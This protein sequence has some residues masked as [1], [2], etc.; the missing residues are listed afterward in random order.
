MPETRPHGIKS[1]FIE[2]IVVTLS[3]RIRSGVYPGG[4]W[5][6]TERELCSEFDV[7]RTTLRQALAELERSSLVMRSAGCRPMVIAGRA[8][9]HIGARNAETARRTIGLQVKHDA[10]F[11]G[12]YQITQGVRE[13]AGAHACRLIVG[14]GS[15]VTLAQAAS[16]EAQTLRDMTR[17]EDVEGIILWH[18]GVESLLPELLAVQQAGIPLVFVDRAPPVGID[19]DFVGIDNR[20]AARAAVSHLISRGHRRI[21]HVTNPEPVSTVSERREG[22]DE[23]MRDAGLEDCGRIFTG[24]LEAMAEEGMAAGEIADTLLSMEEPP[25][26]LF[27]VTDYVALAIVRALEERGRRVPEDFAVVGFDDLEQWL[28]QKPFLTTIRQPFERIGREAAALLA[29]RLDE[30]SNNRFRH[31]VLDA[32]LVLRSSG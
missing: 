17:D 9:S 10:K 2:H 29:R 3:D 4:R 30:P 6:P 14:G 24:R 28:P 26:A 20:G 19:A 12:T 8:S 27:A 18:C 1:P 16:Q 11:S 31:V 21:A 13:A 7:S 32:P 15:A 25:T 5:L 23:A 22:Y